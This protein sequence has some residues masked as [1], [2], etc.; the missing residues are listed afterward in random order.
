MGHRI[1][2]LLRPII[3]QE[4][5]K[6]LAV[7]VGTGIGISQGI[8]NFGDYISRKRK[9]DDFT[10]PRRRKSEIFLDDAPTNGSPNQQY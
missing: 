3:S 7:A 5:D 6:I 4:Y 10:R 8:D 1:V 9:W 2:R